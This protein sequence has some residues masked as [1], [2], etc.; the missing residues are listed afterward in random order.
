MDNQKFF[1]EYDDSCQ[2]FNAV[3]LRV[4]IFFVRHSLCRAGKD[5]QLG[6]RTQ[7]HFVVSQQ[8]TLF[9]PWLNFH[10]MH[11]QTPEF[12]FKNPTIEVVLFSVDTLQHF[13]ESAFYGYFLLVPIKMYFL[14]IWSFYSGCK[15]VEDIT[16]VVN[17]NLAQFGS[18]KLKDIC[19]VAKALR[20]LGHG[21]IAKITSRTAKRPK[22]K[23]GSI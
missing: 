7:S 22:M 8:P 13:I 2:G 16:L 17:L 15:A 20:D 18:W 19:N 23:G 1:H 4:A 10:L 21:N 14:G 11:Q 6:N 3:G 9:F 5:Q 12:S